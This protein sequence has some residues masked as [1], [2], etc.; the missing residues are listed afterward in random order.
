MMNIRNNYE[1][2]IPNP[3]F[4]F[5]W[6][7]RFKKTIG[8]LNL[9][10]IFIGSFKIFWESFGVVKL[11]WHGLAVD[12]NSESFWFLLGVKI[13][14][15]HWSLGSLRSFGS[16]LGWLSWTG[17]DWPWTEIPNPPLFLL[18][19]PFWFL[20]DPFGGQDS[21]KPIKRML[22]L[23]CSNVNWSP[24]AYQKLHLCGSPFS[25]CDNVR[26]CRQFSINESRGLKVVS[27]TSSTFW[28]IALCDTW[29]SE[30]LPTDGVCPSQRRLR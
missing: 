30:R 19:I 4:D 9:Y 16:L 3:P 13:Q 23:F 8:H 22:Q 25:G 1:T 21:K 7:S 24:E 18:L 15:N 10:Y 14:K 6:G 11:D 12:W 2:S 28:S 26:H 29:S 27:E 20:W 5:F 17:M